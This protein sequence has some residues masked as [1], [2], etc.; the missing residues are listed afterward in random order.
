MRMIV[1]QALVP[2]VGGGRIGLREFLVFDE[3]V[4]E[5]LLEQPLERWTAETQ[6]MLV[7]YGQTMEQTASKAFK[8]GLIDRRA[9]LLLLKGFSIE[10]SEPV[11]DETDDSDSVGSMGDLDALEEI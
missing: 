7:R 6:R 9:Y 11:I 1:T 10:D 8:A 5:Y 4:R 3:T 2:K